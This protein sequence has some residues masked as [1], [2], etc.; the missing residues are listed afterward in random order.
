MSKINFD[1]RTVIDL[2][3]LNDSLKNKLFEVIDSELVLFN[4]SRDVERDEDEFALTIAPLLKRHIEKFFKVEF[5]KSDLFL[6]RKTINLKNVDYKQLVDSI[7]KI[8]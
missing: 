1:T 8:S 7:T 4:Y 6:I 5:K 3:T 2:I